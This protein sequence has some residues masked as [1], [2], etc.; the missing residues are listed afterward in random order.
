M[1]RSPCDEF[2]IAAMPVTGAATTGT[3]R[4]VRKG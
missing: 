4:P 3:V 2:D 1:L